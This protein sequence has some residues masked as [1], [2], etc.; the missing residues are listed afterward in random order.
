MKHEKKTLEGKHIR[1]EPLSR[2]HKEGLIETIIDGELWK[3]FVTIVP[4]LDK[5]DEFLENAEKE[6]ERGFGIS[7]AIV[8]KNTN[9]LILTIF[10]W[11]FR[12]S[13]I[14]ILIWNLV[15]FI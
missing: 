11:Q 7:Y 2:S 6:Y 15:Q 8:N 9:S 14:Y 13:H 5:L 12:K 1:L 4:P 10:L 3:L